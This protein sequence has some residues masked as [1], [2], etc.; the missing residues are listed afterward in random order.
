MNRRGGR[1]ASEKWD[2]GGREGTGDGATSWSV[3]AFQFGNIGNVQ[4]RKPSG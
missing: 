2:R 1:K 3:K 4:E